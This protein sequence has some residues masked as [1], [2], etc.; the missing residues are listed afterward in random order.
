[1]LSLVETATFCGVIAAPHPVSGCES[2]VKL[3]LRRDS[4]GRDMRCLG[5]KGI[6]WGKNRIT[7]FTFNIHSHLSGRRFPAVPKNGTQSSI[8]LPQLPESRSENKSP[9][10]RNECFFGQ[11]S[12]P[13]CRNPQ[14][15]GE[16]SYQ[17]STKGDDA[18][19]P[20]AIN[21]PVQ[22]A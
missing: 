17:K 4:S 16:S 21:L 15:G 10:F 7:N 13:R 1:M 11:A 2:S 22:M 6:V 8:Q 20:P 19:V 9:L 14:N 5:S 12:L 3:E 18:I